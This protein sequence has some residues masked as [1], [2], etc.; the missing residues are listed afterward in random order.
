MAPPSLPT[1][2]SPHVV[3]L[4][5]PDLDHLLSETR[6]LPPLHQLLQSFC[7]LPQV[8]TRT[9][10]LTPV[11]HPTFNLRFSSLP[12]IEVACKED[13]DAR[14]ERT[15]D[16]IG[17]RI[18][19]QAASWIENPRM[20]EHERWWTELRA[21]VEGERVPVRG[22]GWNHPVA[23]ILATSTLASNPLKA[24]TKLHASLPDFPAWVEPILFKYTLIVHPTPSELD[25]NEAV[26]LLN[27]VKK[28]FGLNTHLLQLPSSASDEKTSFDVPVPLPQLPS[29]QEESENEDSSDDDDESEEGGEE[30][31]VEKKR[32]REKEWG[33]KLVMSEGDAQNVSRFV[34]EFTTMALVPALE[35]CVG[36][37]NEAFANT[38]RISTRLF[39][40]TAR[41]LFGN[42]GSISSTPTP[43]SSAS[44]SPAF[45]SSAPL[46]TSPRSP[47]SPSAA[48]P[49]PS[50]PPHRRLAEFAT[51]LG[52]YKLA[53][54][55][56][57]VLRKEQPVWTYPPNPNYLGRGRVLSSGAD[58][59]P[60]ILSSAST[61]TG[62]YAQAALQALGFGGA[63]LIGEGGVMLGGGAA[64]QVRAL[65]YA[66]RWE[67][68][69]GDFHSPP[70]NDGLGGR[71]IEGERWLALAAGVAE[72]PTSALLLGRAASISVRKGATRRAALW[73][74]MAGKRLEKSGIKALTIHFFE[75]AN[76]ARAYR[77]DSLSLLSPSFFDIEG[78]SPDGGDAD[79]SGNGGVEVGLSETKA[80]LD[81]ALGRLKYSSGDTHGAVLLFAGLLRPLP[82]S[83]PLA[84]M[85]APSPGVA[86]PAMPI[87][88]INVAK[89]Y[90]DD[91][92]D[93]LEHYISTHPAT[94]PPTEEG[95]GKP[96]PPTPSL[97]S[98]KLPISFARPA[99]TRVQLASDDHHHQSSSGTGSTPTTRSSSLDGIEDYWR[100]F[101]KG[102][103]QAGGGPVKVD[104][105]RAATVGEPFWISV[106]LR[107]PLTA[108]IVLR[109][110]SIGVKGKDGADIVLHK[111]GKEP[112][113]KES[114]GDPETD[115]GIDVETLAQVT[116]PPKSQLRLSFR[117]LVHHPSSSASATLPA[118]YTSLT[119]PTLSYSF[120]GLLPCT[121][122]LAQPGK[123]L[124]D[125][126]QQRM[127]KVYAP[128]KSVS[129]EVKERGISLAASFVSP[130]GSRA[131]EDRE[132]QEEISVFDG[133]VRK[134]RLVIRNAGV[135]AVRDAW[136]I[137]PRDGNIFVP[138]PA[139]ESA[140]AESPVKAS[141]LDAPEPYHLSLDVAGTGVGLA[142]GEST[143]VDVVMRHSGDGAA[144]VDILIV[145]REDEGTNQYFVSRA[146]RNIWIRPLITLSAAVKPAPVSASAV[147]AGEQGHVDDGPMYSLVLEVENV[148]GPND[149]SIDRVGTLS[150]AWRFSNS[151]S[152]PSTCTPLPRL[153][154]TRATLPIELLPPTELD[155]QKVIVNPFERLSKALGAVV[156]GK[157]VPAPPPS[158]GDTDL[159]FSSASAS[160]GEESGA[161][162]A[163]YASFI[164]AARRSA[165]SRL[166]GAEFSSVPVGDYARIFPLWTGL[167]CDVIL[168]WSIGGSKRDATAESDAEEEEEDEDEDEDEE[169]EVDPDETISSL[170]QPPASPSPKSKPKP[171][172][173]PIRRGLISLADAGDLLSLGA[174]HGALRSALPDGA[175]GQ[176]GGRTMYAET[177][178]ER[179]MLVRAVREGRWNEERCPVRVNVVIPSDADASGGESGG[180]G[181]GRRN[182]D[183][184]NGPCVFPLLFAIRNES[185]TMSVKVTLKLRSP[186][187]RPGT[188]MFR[189]IG[190]LTK[191]ATIGA[192]GR[193]VIPA[194]VVVPA[195]GI[196]DVGS[197][198]LVTEVGD[199]KESGWKEWAR[200]VDVDEDVA[201]AVRLEVLASA[202]AQLI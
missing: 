26:A 11:T 153:Q 67:V 32:G 58:V 21:C 122:S 85:I 68:G 141:T 79:E 159:V 113:A 17:S 53:S 202:E 145:F 165:L 186:P 90:C 73:F 106:G 149:L 189:Y 30:G 12:T 1:S 155:V 37:W 29:L 86:D 118:S 146:R 158:D 178:R 6:Q 7:P 74:A 65:A 124:N 81:H 151:T 42:S 27:A 63:P 144:S 23:L 97:S 15:I 192:R 181:I 111:A 59:L 50:L 98:I 20:V 197:W 96:Q 115:I 87:V 49:T 80:F 24:I 132:E 102:R 76:E 168:E 174:R 160:N 147:S 57:D 72:E 112:D 95:E 35:R 121:E 99:L 18:A 84:L 93:A 108:E 142:P 114:E 107:N 150:T 43:T 105:R 38:R 136:L 190:A 148:G 4:T 134:E 166:I 88:D 41:R 137:L 163:S 139:K 127:G 82:T 5:T 51:L 22:E 143:S 3:V 195:P 185:V 92:R 109:D 200:Y 164:Q 162:D 61:A 128:E 170:P 45:G 152:L 161:L 183:F 176:K 64:A 91:F 172:K 31:R 131:D 62:G 196:V 169:E 182:W 184:G 175:D 28:Q 2:L 138:S 123:R 40:S 116:L 48:L 173:R 201:D 33:G 69:V 47:T 135:R 56:F 194:K 117:V 133:E 25:P 52:D 66:V 89:M 71:G 19:Q 167:D 8:T 103:A 119:F 94:P 193:V 188:S 110:V 70:P 187:T 191:R 83:S 129:I 171:F 140:S 46:P 157:P 179:E 177:A 36:E 104:V 9:S 34:R 120:L 39:G 78:I 198:E 44:P 126:A 10:A 180:A 75:R 154:L 199:E 54:A 125:T 77:K 14:A 13:E 100:A 16:W 60:L 130:S 55:V 156:E 101:Q